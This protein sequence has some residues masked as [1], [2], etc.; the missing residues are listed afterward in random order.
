M[1]VDM[2][3]SPVDRLLLRSVRCPATFSR[4]GEG[5]DQP[6]SLAVRARRNA[7]S[8]DDR[9]GLDGPLGQGTG[10]RDLIAQTEQVSVRVTY[11]YAGFDCGS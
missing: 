5:V 2:A 4:G 11:G 8:A 10:K 7:G 3:T 1:R 6:P 9:L